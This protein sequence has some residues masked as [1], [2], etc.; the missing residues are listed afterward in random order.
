MISCC[1]L[2]SALTVWDWS[3]TARLEGGLCLE[4]PLKSPT[5]LGRAA[6]QSMSGC[7]SALMIATSCLIRLTISPSIAPWSRWMSPWV[8]LCWRSP[9]PVHLVICSFLTQQVRSS[10]L[11]DWAVLTRWW[12]TRV[13]R[14]R[15][16]RR[17]Q[18]RVSRHRSVPRCLFLLKCCKK[19]ISVSSVS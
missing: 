9:W 17:Q 4:F 10:E 18:R 6:V 2:L 5:M 13:H 14:R 3:W 19:R 7:L 11:V 12:A 16:P 1:S 8:A 15:R